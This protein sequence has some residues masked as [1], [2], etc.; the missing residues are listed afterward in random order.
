MPE[1]ADLKANDPTSSGSLSG[2]GSLCS[3]LIPISTIIYTCAALSIYP[4]THIWS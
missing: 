1:L 2:V 3:H 4:Y